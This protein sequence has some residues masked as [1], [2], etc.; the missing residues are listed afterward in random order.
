M[1]QRLTEFEY[2]Q[3]TTALI[4]YRV[5]IYAKSEQPELN[6]HITRT[7][8]IIEELRAP[9]L[10]QPLMPK[11]RIHLKEALV[12]E[13]LAKGSSFGGCSSPHRRYT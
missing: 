5:A 3:H 11:Q 10:Q 9:C 1:R 12:L 6:W 13:N 8:E 7:L 2:Q 4:D